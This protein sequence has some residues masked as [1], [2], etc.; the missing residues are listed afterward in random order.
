MKV[1]NKDGSSIEGQPA[2]G[3]TGRGDRAKEIVI[4]ATGADLLRIIA[5]DIRDHRSTQHMQV[6]VPG[7]GYSV[8]RKIDILDAIAEQIENQQAINRKYQTKGKP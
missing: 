5:A 4:T 2:T 1:S 3:E 7:Y 8:E 6:R